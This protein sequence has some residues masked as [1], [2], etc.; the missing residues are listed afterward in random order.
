MIADEAWP[1]DFEEQPKGKYVIK[2]KLVR[3]SFLELIIVREN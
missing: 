1:S 3:D 2:A